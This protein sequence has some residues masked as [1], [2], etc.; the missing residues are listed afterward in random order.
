[1]AA[2]RICASA[3]TSMPSATGETASPKEPTSAPTV[4]STRASPMISATETR[5]RCPSP[6]SMRAPATALLTRSLVLRRLR[7]STAPV[8]PPIATVPSWRM[9]YESIAAPSR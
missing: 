2:E 6:D 1:M 7:P 4:A 8:L 5:R 3:S 9:E